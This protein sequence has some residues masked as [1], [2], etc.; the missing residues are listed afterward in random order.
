[1]LTQ[2]FHLTT[3]DRVN[4]TGSSLPQN[5]SLNHLEPMLN[6]DLQP[7]LNAKYSGLID[8]LT[9]KPYSRMVSGVVDRLLIVIKGGQENA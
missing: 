7:L 5:A 2:I 9:Q 3:H 1:M 8:R 6:G 4:F